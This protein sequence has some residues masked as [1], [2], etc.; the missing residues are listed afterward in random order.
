MVA[1]PKPCPHC[2][3]TGHSHWT[4]I[5]ILLSSV[6]VWAVPI[7]FLRLGSY[8]FGILLAT[9]LTFWAVRRVR[10]VCSHCGR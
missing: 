1:T 2:G 4:G 10:R 7:T 6:L 8:P 5:G 9:I 3:M